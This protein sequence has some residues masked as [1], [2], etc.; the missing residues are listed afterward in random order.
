MMKLE[1]KNK[2]QRIYRQI[3]YKQI[4]GISRLWTLLFLKNVN[5]YDF[6]IKIEYIVTVHRSIICFKNYNWV[7]MTSNP[8]YELN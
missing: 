6:V 1:E 8:L 2:F 7:L 5:N 4:N 3:Y